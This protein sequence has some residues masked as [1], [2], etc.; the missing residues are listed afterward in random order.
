M[1]VSS[2]Y[3]SGFSRYF[4][5]TSGKVRMGR[6]SS[7]RPPSI[8]GQLTMASQRCVRGGTNF[9]A[10]FPSIV[11]RSKQQTKQ[12]LLAYSQLSTNDDH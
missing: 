6:L 10:I 7:S 9:P 3:P 8:S 11:L 12:I 5:P 2:L 1:V 4:R